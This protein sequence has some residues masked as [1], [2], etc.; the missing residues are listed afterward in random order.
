MKDEK[1]WEA[2]VVTVLVLVGVVGLA[3]V[4]TVIGIAAVSIVS[5]VWSAFV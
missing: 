2:P 5:A 1:W 4:G 3:L